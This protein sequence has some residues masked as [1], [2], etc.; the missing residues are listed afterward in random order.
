MPGMGILSYGYIQGAS[1]SDIS[2]KKMW[3]GNA[4]T[5]SGTEIELGTNTFAAGDFAANDLMIV[6]VEARGVSG[7]SNADFKLRVNDG[8]N[9][10]TTAQR[11]EFGAGG[12][13]KHFICFISQ[14]E[15]ATTALNSSF[16]GITDTVALGTNQ[17]NADTEATMIANWITTAFTLS[18][19]GWTPGGGGTCYFKWWVVKV[20]A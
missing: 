8:T 9:T 6:F 19:R 16:M 2:V 1:S 4:S 14:G 12:V 10:F 15:A 13:G 7:V 20:T 3:S 5:S 18:F 11:G 17:N